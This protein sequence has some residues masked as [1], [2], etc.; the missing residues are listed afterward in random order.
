M[1]QYLPFKF[2]IYFYI[3]HSLCSSEV[4][5]EWKSSENMKII[6][7]AVHVRRMFSNFKIQLHTNT[8]FHL[9]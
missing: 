5:I 2:S 3:I 4:D 6:S 8:I 7:H 9:A 1:Q